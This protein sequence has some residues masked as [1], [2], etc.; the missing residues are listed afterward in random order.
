VWILDLK[1]GIDTF[2]MTLLLCSLE[3]KNDC[4]VFL[5]ISEQVYCLISLLEAGSWKNDS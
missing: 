4:Y 3:A 2:Y 5:L 1:L